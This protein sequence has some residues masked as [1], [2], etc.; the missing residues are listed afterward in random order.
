[1]AELRQ[2]AR[3]TWLFFETF[4][5]DADNWLPPDNY[6]E[7]P[8]G[9]VAHRTSPTNQGLLLLST[10]AAHDF[11]YI[12]IR[13]LV[14]RLGKS[15]D[16]FDKMEKHW[17]HFY[18][19]YQTTTLKPLQPLY[20]STVDSGNLLGCLVALQQA[21][22][23]LA[24]G[25]FFPPTKA[26]L[27]DSLALVAEALK[28][29]TV[30]NSEK[31]Q[32][33]HRQLV[34]DL[35]S[36]SGELSSEPDDLIGRHEWL[37]RLDWA[38]IGLI[39]RIKA[40]QEAI[41]ELPEGL[42]TWAR[43]F[44]GE[45]TSRRADL[46]ALAPWIVPLKDW[47]AAGPHAW[48][49]EETASRWA[50]IRA[51]LVTPAG[52]ARHVSL[53][54][55][56]ADRLEG[57][58]DEGLSKVA[59]A[60][61]TSSAADLHD[62]LLSL[63]DRSEAHASAMEFDHLYKADR[64]LY[65]IGCNL[66]QGRLDG[67]CYDLLASES[68]LTSFLTIAR[69]DAPRRHWFHLG[70]PFIE[71]AGEVG[72]MSWG[73]TMFEYL[74][75]RLLIKGLAG[76]LLAE[77]NKTAVARQIE[78]G[79]QTGFPWGISESAFNAQYIDG[80]F[81]YQ[82]FGVPGL[83]LK[84]GLEKD[85]VVA[86]YATALA[87]MIAPREA[88]DN[89]RRLAAD[90]ALGPYGFYEAVDFTPNRVPKGKRCVVV[91]QYM[92]HHQGMSLVGLANSLLDEPMP[93]R[94]HAVPMVRAVDLLLQERIPRDATIIEPSE[95]I[96]PA[97][98][99]ETA[100]AKAAPLMSRR[101]TTAATPAPRVHLIS[102]TQY[103]V[104][105]TNAG[106]GYSTC[107]GLDVTRW[108]EDITRDNW[109]Q[110]IYLRDMGTGQLWSSAHHP[111]GRLAD[112]YEV[113]FSADKAAFRRRD[114]M[115]ET[116]TE[117]TVSPEGLA[118]V[119][120]VTLTNH[121]TRP[122]EVELTSYAE[123]VLLGRGADLA[124][125]AFGKLF[126]ETEWLAGSQALLCRRRPRASDQAPIWAVHVVASDTPSANDIQFETDRARFLGRGRSP[127][128]PA[129]LDPGVSLSGTTGP[130]LDPIVSLRKRVKIDP[131]GT[132]VVAFSTGVADS[133]AEAVAMADHY[134][135][136]S[137]A[138]RAFEVSWRIARSSIARRTIRPRTSTC[139][140]GSPPTSYSRARP[141]VPRP[142]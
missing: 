57:L 97:Q 31:A 10:L 109:G 89:F 38:A 29:V 135:Q 75:P 48:P 45:V 84:R 100:T 11:G 62:R 41:P 59:R 56:L 123:V 68:C 72:L 122:H 118:E 90:G 26:G 18:N 99:P 47:E 49:D 63:A 133:R 53:A 104:M 39:G 14:D 42:E 67:A 81:Q 16:T 125:P 25:P 73:G 36:L 44:A 5:G 132:A 76:T 120:R 94:F 114:G 66:T 74:M 111:T 140:R 55:A 46:D 21:L 60:I 98:S 24:E 54:E 130:V 83:G 87:T 105:L 103:H 92:A 28:G 22:V 101:L 50:A 32:A 19:W 95:A 9:R 37:G 1:M 78:Y 108:R 52:L 35:Q 116:L 93:R 91:K 134:R 34:E 64:N 106:G 129:A 4:V 30:P 70:R 43:R 33:T 77:A 71:A 110:F 6:Q 79:V 7:D 141:C 15:F 51:E 12:G 23:E 127:A 85:H 69:G 119:R 13:T 139:S 17:G 27:G 102:N 136:S 117:V 142:P 8:D 112:T 131:A 80:D 126:V 121:D 137:A 96:A 82:S 138:A 113:V 107:R 128:S 20:I 65:A 61:A 86:P 40:L 2:V 88:V 115:I 58:H 124:H 3:R